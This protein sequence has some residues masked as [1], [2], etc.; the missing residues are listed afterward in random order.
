MKK[1]IVAFLLAAI[2]TAGMGVSSFAAGTNT[3]ARNAAEYEL[4]L[5]S[6]EQ[7]DFHIQKEGAHHKTVA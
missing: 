1:K 7:K 4:I 5:R 3:A 2:M 6:A